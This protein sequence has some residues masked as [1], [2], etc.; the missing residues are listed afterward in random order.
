DKP[1]DPDFKLMNLP[2]GR[3]LAY[4]GAAD[5]V[6]AAIVGLTFDDTKPATAFD[7]SKAARVVTRTFDGL[8]VTIQVLQKGAD[9]WATVS[10]QAEP[11]KKSAE[12]EAKAI[13]AKTSGR[14]YK[15]PAFKGQPLMTKQATLLKPLNPPKGAKPAP[16]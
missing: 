13:N 2:A 8:T 1:K 12:K 3:E 14:A 15:L 16:G 6:A 5:N 9:Y 10:A 11:G 4:P 7:F